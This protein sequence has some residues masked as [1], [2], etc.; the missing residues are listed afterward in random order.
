MQ[1][2]LIMNRTKYYKSVYNSP[3]GKLTIACDNKE[4]IVGLWTEGQ[5]YFVNTIKSEIQE[6]NE[7][8]IFNMTKNWLNRYFKGENPAIKELPLKPAGSDF[9]REIW[10]LLCSIPYGKTT[11][12]GEIAKI[13]AKN[14]GV[15]I[16]SAQ[17][18]GGAV[19]HNPISI[20]IP[21]HRVIGK[22]GH[23]TG[24]AGGI[25]TKIKLLKTEGINI[26]G[27]FVV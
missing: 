2:N 24:Y 21:C 3:V 14:R 20:I 1:Q 26:K 12:Y 22:N 13:I 23:L 5:S 27:M 6:M 7:L 17:A 19:G 10:K 25:E 15:K 18:V 16:V 9:R 4:N 8:E 11:T